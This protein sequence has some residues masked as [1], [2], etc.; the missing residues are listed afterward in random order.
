MYTETPYSVFE[1]P[2]ISYVPAGANQLASVGRYYIA[3][4]GRAQTD[5]I[6]PAYLVMSQG[7]VVDSTTGFRQYKWNIPKT[8]FINAEASMRGSIATIFDPAYDT[9]LHAAWASAGFD[10]DA[11]PK[12]APIAD[13]IVDAPIRDVNDLFILHSN[14]ACSLYNPGACPQ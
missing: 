14:M 2:S 12:F 4:N 8:R 3:W 7:N 11:A 1:R 9:N 13:D 6:G 10:E 5:A